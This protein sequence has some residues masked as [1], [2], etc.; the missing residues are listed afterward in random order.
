MFD[1]Y[2]KDYDSEMDFAFF[3]E[4]EEIGKHERKER[5]ITEVGKSEKSNE[6]RFSKLWFNFY[7]VNNLGLNRP[8]CFIPL[9]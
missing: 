8:L 7:M 2:S 3:E 4:D 1:M 9:F 5:W 6:I